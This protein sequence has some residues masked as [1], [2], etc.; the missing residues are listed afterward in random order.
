MSIPTVVTGGFGGSIADLVR[1]G[2]GSGGLVQES[3][4]LTL[5]WEV[6]ASPRR[7][8]LG[9]AGMRRAVHTSYR[10]ELRSH[11]NLFLGD[12]TSAFV[13]DVGP[14]GTID[15]NNDRAALRT[16]RFIIDPSKAA[17]DPFEDH[18]AVLA[19]TTI[20]FGVIATS[21]LGL[22]HLTAPRRTYRPRH[23][24]W[25]VEATDLTVHLLEDTCTDTYVVAAGVNYITGAN[26]VKAILDAKGLRYALPTTALTVPADKP[27]EAGTPWLTIVNE[28]LQGCNM[29]DIWPDE[30][31]QFTTRLRTDLNART[32]DIAFTGDDFIL[33]PVVEE[34][35]TTRFAN[36]ILA[37]SED[38]NVGILRSVK[39]NNDP[40]SPTSIVNLG[41]TIT[42]TI[43]PQAANQT[44][45]DE[46]A[47]FELQQ[48]GS[49]YRRANIL[50]QPDPRRGAHEVYS[51]TIDLQD[52]GVPD[53]AGPYSTQKWWC[54]NWSLDLMPGAQMKHTI[55]KV[56]KVLTIT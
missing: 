23:E 42:K 45:L 7:T 25:E 1:T 12:I 26:G 9:L 13:R 48:S 39:A 40:D 46:I 15:L 53:S 34:A 10:F 44:T 49:I 11:A 33:S 16:A 28:L 2:F 43:R 41:R 8:H 27:W 21:Q 52:T 37:I 36:R 20:D 6:G 56:E 55:A 4:D 14:A 29:Y 18:I 5:H 31:G 51:I 32:V 17:I 47:T 22:F 30:T 3:Y 38:P 19:D 24:I 54:R 35:E 50:T